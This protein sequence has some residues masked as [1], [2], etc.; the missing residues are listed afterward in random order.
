MVPSADTHP[1]AE[2]VY[3]FRRAHLHFKIDSHGCHFKVTLLTPRTTQEFYT[4]R[5]S[6]PASVPYST[7][8][9]LWSSFVPQEAFN[10]PDEY[11]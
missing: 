2:F 5:Y 10:I 11:D 6:L 4:I 3:G 8:R 7:A 9:T 1:R